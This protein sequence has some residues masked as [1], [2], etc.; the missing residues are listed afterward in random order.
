MYKEKKVTDDIND[1]PTC[2]DCGCPIP[3]DEPIFDVE[4]KDLCE[5]CAWDQLRKLPKRE[6]LKEFY[7]VRPS[8]RRDN[9]T[10]KEDGIF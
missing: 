6:I 9:G 8:R 7:T 3:L 4:G 2:Q 1:M 5:F 10:S